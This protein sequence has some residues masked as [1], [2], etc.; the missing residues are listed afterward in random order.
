MVIAHS[1][2]NFETQ[3]T[4][5]TQIDSGCENQYN[6]IHFKSKGNLKIIRQD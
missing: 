1:A 6:R 3:I 5:I 4:L 2:L